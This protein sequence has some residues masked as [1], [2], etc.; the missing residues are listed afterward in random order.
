MKVS[1]TDNAHRDPSGRTRG[2]HLF[3]TVVVL[4]PLR[5]MSVYGQTASHQ[6]QAFVPW[7]TKTFQAARGTTHSFASPKAS[8]GG[9]TPRSTQRLHRLWQYL[10][11][12]STA[13]EKD[14][15][16]RSGDGPSEPHKVPVECGNVPNH[17][18]SRSTGPLHQEFTNISLQCPPHTSTLLASDLHHSLPCLHSSARIR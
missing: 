10:V 3:I 5:P 13:D 17:C 8:L 16:C 7:L 2:G 6:T 9:K 18:V 1:E 11:S 4:S 15:Q 12:S 14:E